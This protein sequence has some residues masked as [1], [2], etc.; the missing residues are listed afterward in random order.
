MGDPPRK[1]EVVVGLLGTDHNGV[2]GEHRVRLAPIRIIRQDEHTID[3]GDQVEGCAVVLQL[4]AKVPQ[5]L[6]LEEVT[7]PDVE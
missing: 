2:R 1:E 7:A 5:D 3:V 4:L 6:L